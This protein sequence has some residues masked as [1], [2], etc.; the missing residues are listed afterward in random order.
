MR[1]NNKNKKKE[2]PPPH[3][4]QEMRVFVFSAL[5]VQIS[6]SEGEKTL[7]TA[8]RGGKEWKEKNEIIITVA[9]SQRQQHQ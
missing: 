9:V 1:N 7:H 2:V 5:W 4:E 8:E 3:K 6:S